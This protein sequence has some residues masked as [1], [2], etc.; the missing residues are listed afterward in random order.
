MQVPLGNTE[1]FGVIRSYLACCASKAR[2]LVVLQRAFA[3]N[4]VDSTIAPLFPGCNSIMHSPITN[5]VREVLFVSTSLP[6][7]LSAGAVRC[8]A[9]TDFGLPMTDDVLSRFD[10][11]ACHLNREHH[12]GSGDAHAIW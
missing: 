7:I 11:T 8:L 2:M 12:R 3:G 5:A 1:D 4:P 9:T 6:S 10:R